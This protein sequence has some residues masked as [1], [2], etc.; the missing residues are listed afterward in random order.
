MTLTS[1][2]AIS[3]HITAMD[4]LRH[5]RALAKEEQIA[6]NEERITGILSGCTQWLATALTLPESNSLF[7]FQGQMQQML[8]LIIIDTML[9]GAICQECVGHMIHYHPILRPDPMLPRET[10]HM[11]IG[12]LHEAFGDKLSP[13]FN[14]WGTLDQQKQLIPAGFILR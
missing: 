14:I 10:F 4:G 5:I 11:T 13:E 8:Q 7:M 6:Y 3:E 1:P 12:F 2:I 9:Y